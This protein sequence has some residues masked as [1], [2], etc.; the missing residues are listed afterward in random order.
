MAR[1]PS[2]GSFACA[3]ASAL[4]LGSPLAQ[5]QLLG[6]VDPQLRWRFLDT[7]HFSV[8]FAEQNRP[9]ARIA[10]EVAEKVYP[11][12][13]GMLRWQPRGR[14]HLIVLD[15][16][17]FSN[18][19]ATPLPFNHSGIFLSPPDEGELLQSRVWLELVLTHE[20]FHVVHLDKARGAPLGFRNVFG[21]WAPFFPNALEPGWIVEG[22][23]GYAESDA[24]K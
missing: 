19:F 14:T 10:A 21:R 24:G 22:L 13:T 11:R 8:H 23:A 5:A 17:D 15:S 20:F 9:Q 1:P 12:I 6:F 18:G 4:L 7:A 3:L 2:R 16:A